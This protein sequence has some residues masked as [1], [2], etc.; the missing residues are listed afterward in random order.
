MTFAKKLKV[1]ISKIATLNHSLSWW[2][3]WDMHALA[4][5]EKNAHVKGID[6]L[7]INLKVRNMSSKVILP[8][9]D[10]THAIVKKNG[11]FVRAHH[12]GCVRD[13]QT[14]WI[15]Q[16]STNDDL[17]KKPEVSIFKIATVN[18]LEHS[19]CG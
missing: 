18:P 19:G 9:N 8:G 17:C 15:S 4:P 1:S 2:S 10:V 5:C 3:F 14:A 7:E 13:I 11:K 12:R 16:L 6:C